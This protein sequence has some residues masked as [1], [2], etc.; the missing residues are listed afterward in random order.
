MAKKRTKRKPSDAPEDVS[1]E[2]AGEPA[3]SE[4]IGAREVLCGPPEEPAP[5]AVDATPEDTRSPWGT[6]GNWIIIAINKQ[7]FGAAHRVLAKDWQLNSCDGA[8]DPLGDAL[9]FESRAE[10]QEY[11]DVYI[12]GVS[13]ARPHCF[14]SYT[15]LNMG[16]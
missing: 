2:T 9:R 6:V 1:E 12:N 14:Y 13:L 16:D 11:I 4:P 5:P 7:R 8:R 10:A 3:S 15:P